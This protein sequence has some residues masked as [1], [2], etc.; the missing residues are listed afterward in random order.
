MTDTPQAALRPAEPRIDRTITLHLQGDW[1]AMNLHRVCGWISMELTDRCGPGTR[2]AIWNGRGFVDG[3]H[4]V[5]R[6]EVDVALV[7][8]AAFVTAALD[9]RGVYGG[10]RYPDLRGLGVVPQRDRLVMGVSRSWGI[11][12]FAELRRRRPALRLATSHDDG[13]N[14]VGL[15]ARELLER[16]GVDIEGWGGTFLRDERPFETLAHVREGRADAIIHEAVMLPAWQEIGRDLHFLPVEEPVLEALGSDLDW[17]AAELPAGYFP[18]APVLRT[19]DFSDFLVL[20]RADLPDDVAY[21][22][23]WVLG[24]TRAV[25][26]QQYTHLAPERSPVTYPLD[27]VAMGRTPVPLHAG[28][29]AYYRALP[30]PE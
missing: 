1:G 10:S 7:T 3:V 14:H 11:T 15:A 21:G 24:E 26:E 20:T 5:G 22:I 23:A 18:D 27:P 29:A 30:R 19:L 2:T 25:L 4:A 8:P 28:A 6:R 9:G 12:S 17:P 16:S 13:V